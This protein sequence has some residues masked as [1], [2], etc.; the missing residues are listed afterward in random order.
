MISVDLHPSLL[1][2]RLVFYTGA[3]FSGILLCSYKKLTDQCSYFMFIL[4][5]QVS[6]FFTDTPTNFRTRLL[7]DR[8]FCRVK[9]TSRE[10][11]TRIIAQNPPVK[12]QCTIKRLSC[13]EYLVENTHL[14]P[15]KL[16][17]NRSDPQSRT[18]NIR[19][20][21]YIMTCFLRSSN[22]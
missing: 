21:P 4:S 3:H 20:Q 17:S 5:R 22:D 14:F 19:V 1:N 13:S 15:S 12:T 7:H 18:G 16:E 11:H 2:V 10:K 8:W 6:R 9:C